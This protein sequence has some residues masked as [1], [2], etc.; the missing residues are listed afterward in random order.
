MK[1]A[2]FTP[3][4]QNSAIGKYSQCIIEELKNHSEIDLW[5]PGEEDDL[6]DAEVKVVPFKS[7]NFQTQRLSEY[8]CIVYNMGDH[9]GFHGNI[10]EVSKNVKGVVILHDFVMH[11]FFAAYYLSHLKDSNAYIKEMSR[12]YG[13]EGQ[14]TAEGSLSGKGQPIWE[15]DGVMKYPFFEKAIEGSRGVIVHSSFMAEEIKKIYLGPVAL[16]YHPFYK[17]PANTIEQ[18]NRASSGNIK[19]QVLMITVGNINSNKRIDK[20]IKVIGENK[21]LASKVNYIIIG[22]YDENGSYFTLLQLLL[23]KYGLQ[24]RVKFLGYQPDAIL[25][26]YL[27]RADICLNLRFPAMEGASWSLVEQLQFG[28]PV[29]V[30]DTG[31]CSE[32]PDD[33]VVK[34]DPNQ[35]D[36]ELTMML[37]KLISDASL[38]DKMGQK[39]REFAIRNFSSSKYC[40]DFLNFYNDVRSARPLLDLT[41]RVGLELSLMKA[42]ENMETI[43]VAANEIYKIFKSKLDKAK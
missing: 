10:Y 16:I 9:F 37:N 17:Y 41:D 30:T 19:E 23:R 25:N 22:Q 42:T 34:I 33:C 12:L 14:R 15:T 38:R 32:M 35:E 18:D 3:F 6:L 2:W 20:V 11:H 27:A 31:F 39:G 1:I 13:V 40:K 21:S 26:S 5:V 7:D 8:D 28:K 36:E 4:C 29:I 43:T 24:D